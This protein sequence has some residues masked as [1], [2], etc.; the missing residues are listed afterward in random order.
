MQRIVIAG[1][2]IAFGVALLGVRYLAPDSWF[3]SESNIIEAQQQRDELQVLR[4]NATTSRPG[5]EREA[6]AAR[7]AV[8]DEAYRSGPKQRIE[9][10]KQRR[11]LMRT[12]TLYGG[13]LLLLIGCALPFVQPR[14]G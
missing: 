6:A 1:A 4:H 5:Q 11:D 10:A 14:D 7:L 13:G 12:A 3:L 8:A 9:S 2:L